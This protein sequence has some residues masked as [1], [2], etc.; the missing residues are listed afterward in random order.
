MGA[1]EVIDCAGGGLAVEVGCPGA[2]DGRGEDEALHFGMG[3]HRGKGPDYRIG[4]Y[5]GEHA[6]G[7]RVVRGDDGR[8]TGEA[9]VVWCLRP[10]EH[11]CR[12]DKCLIDHVSGHAGGVVAETTT[13]FKACPLLEHGD[14]GR[15]QPVCQF[16]TLSGEVAERFEEFDR[17]D[18]CDRVKKLVD[19]AEAESVMCSSGDRGQALHGLSLLV[20]VGAC[21]R[22]RVDHVEIIQDVRRGRVS[23]CAEASSSFDACRPGN[24]ELSFDFGGLG[25]RCGCCFLA[26]LELGLQVRELTGR[27]P[28]RATGA[29]FGEEVERDAID[30]HPGRVSDGDC[31]LDPAHV[32]RQ[33]GRLLEHALATAFDEPHVLAVVRCEFDHACVTPAKLDVMR[34]LVL[35]QGHPP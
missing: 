31:A 23:R 12:T 29:V 19:N 32:Q 5:V 8:W 26:L 27:I 3:K 4:G 1:C 30:A 9:V 35:V 21:F 6:D 14:G 7:F 11:S 28:F 17:P 33:P 25:L 10:G 15:N 22:V 2:A 34:E 20:G 13:G 16:G 24:A 18:G